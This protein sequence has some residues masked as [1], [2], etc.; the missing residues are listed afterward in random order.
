[1]VIYNEK[2]LVSRLVVRLLIKRR[3]KNGWLNLFF[4]FVY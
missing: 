4:G 3:N 1:M 2:F